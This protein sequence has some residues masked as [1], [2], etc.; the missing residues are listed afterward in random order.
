M[1]GST[2]SRS[3]SRGRSAATGRNKEVEN[4]A[5]QEGEADLEDLDPDPL[6][7]EVAEIGRRLDLH[8]AGSTA[9]LD[10]IQG[11]ISRLFAMMLRMESLYARQIPEHSPVAE[12]SSVRQQSHRLSTPP[13][14]P[15]HSLSPIPELP[16]PNS[17]PHFHQQPPFPPHLGNLSP[18][19][20]SVV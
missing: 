10:K 1:G 9:T 16:T 14:N 17:T 3:S 13:P 20:K 15:I 8:Q 4:P 11:E 18:D 12:V 2:R 6:A 7:Q 5:I 19:R